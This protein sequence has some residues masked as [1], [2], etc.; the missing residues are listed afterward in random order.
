M[1]HVSIK[2]KSF[3]ILLLLAFYGGAVFAQKKEDDQSTSKK[4]KHAT[5]TLFGQA[6]FYSNKFE[7][8]RTANGETFTHKKLSAACNSLPLGTWIRVTNL[9]N[10]KS[11]IV[12]VNDRLHK[13]TKRLVDL[14]IAAAKK[15]GFFT[16]GLT[17]VKVEVLNKPQ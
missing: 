15:L 11:V 12:K 6:S 2:E 5:K 16:L 17:R 8:R 7:G 9:K 3:I 1:A 4:A 10:D 14:S 13:K